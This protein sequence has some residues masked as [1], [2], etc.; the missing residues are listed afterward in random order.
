MHGDVDR[1]L[2][3]RPLELLREQALAA[4]RGQRLPARLRPVAAGVE[5]RDLARELRP[6]R[7]EEL[8]DE[9]GLPHR[10]RRPPGADP[11]R[12]DGSREGGAHVSLEAGIPKRSRTAAA[13]SAASPWSAFSRSCAVGAC[14]SLFTS[15]WD[16]LVTCAAISGSTSP[17]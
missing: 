7:R 8:D 4:D 1:A 13:R 17:R 3:K 15:A 14:R 9:L 16:S 6:R 2:A 5:R 10:E 12:G 11:H